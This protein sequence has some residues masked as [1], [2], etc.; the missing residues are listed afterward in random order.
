MGEQPH[1]LLVVEDRLAWDKH[2]PT[3]LTGG[4]VHKVLGPAARAK[5]HERHR[6][7]PFKSLSKKKSFYHTLGR[8]VEAINPNQGI[9]RASFIA[10]SPHRFPR[11]EHLTDNRR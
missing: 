2:C 6:F 8:G 1:Q 11:G 7:S 4:S 3:L 5:P 10:L 9:F